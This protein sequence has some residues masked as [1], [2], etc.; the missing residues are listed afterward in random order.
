MNFDDFWQQAMAHHGS[1]SAIE[2]WFPRTLSNAQLKARSDADYLSLI[3]RRVFRAGMTHKVVDDRWP[4]FEKAF[5]GF[6][7]VACQLIDDDR[8]EK[9]MQDKSLI[10]HWR[11]M[12]TI[13]IN[14]QM[15]SDISMAN[16]GF[17]SFIAQWPSNNIIGLWAELK[18]KGAHL[19]GASAAR[20]LR[21]AGKDTF[22]I[23]DDVTRALINAGVITK[24]PTSQRD[25]ATVQ[26]CFNE[27]QKQS[28]YKM[29]ELSMV[30][31]MSIGR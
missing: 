27:L 11:K 31:A 23:T 19:G 28:G 29:G 7:P 3:S 10:R 16:D 24:N 9:L 26:Q 22:V 4:A 17:G 25:L 1:K 30:L 15:V 5:W 13:P 18:K 20:F 2:R 12:K 14:A 21:L 8:F 6:N